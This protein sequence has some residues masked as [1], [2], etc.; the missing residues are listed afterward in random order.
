M[1]FDEQDGLCFWCDEPLRSWQSADA[2]RID[3]GADYEDAYWSGDL[4]LMHRGCHL[5]VHTR[6]SSTLVTVAAA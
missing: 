2:H 6:L 3:P 1:L 4:V 5:S